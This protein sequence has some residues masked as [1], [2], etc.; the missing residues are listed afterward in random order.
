MIAEHHRHNA[1]QPHHPSHRIKK[2][3]TRP[4]TKNPQLSLVLRFKIA[5]SFSRRISNR[6]HIQVNRTALLL[7]ESFTQLLHMH[8]SPAMNREPSVDDHGDVERAFLPFS[9]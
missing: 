3:G 9:H 7:N 5:P 8:L 4:D 1:E 6:S 2:S